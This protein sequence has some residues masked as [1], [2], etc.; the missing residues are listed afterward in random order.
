MS[1]T[2]AQDQIVME[3]PDTLVWLDEYDWSPVMQVAEH[4]ITGA[5]LVQ[6]STR[7]AG[8]PIT[9]SGT[10]APRALIDALFEW[11]SNPADMVLD[12]RGRVFAVRWRHGGIPVGAEP[13]LPLLAD[14]V[15][16]SWYRITLRLMEV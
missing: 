1:V 8:R 14:P 5:L 13:L 2:L 11:L 6:E 4:G 9:L 16:D 15:A 10:A 12:F 3:L 7:L